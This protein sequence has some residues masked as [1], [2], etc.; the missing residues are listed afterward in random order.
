MSIDFAILSRDAAVLILD[1][2]GERGAEGEYLRLHYRDPSI[3]AAEPFKWPYLLGAQ[4]F[5]P[6]Y[7]E[8]TGETSVK[9]LRTADVPT[10]SVLADHVD[11]FNIHA[12]FLVRG[13]E[14]QLDE[15]ESLW[16]DDFVTFGLIRE[17]LLTKNE[18]RRA[19]S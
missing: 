12:T 3:G 16:G 5:E 18:L 11:G 9:E 19:P 15:A 14:W 13:E 17:P 7:D 10:A 8:V 1:Q 2:F 4:R 6:I